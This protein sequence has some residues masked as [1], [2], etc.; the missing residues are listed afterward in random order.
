MRVCED[1]LFLSVAQLSRR[2]ACR[3][4]QAPGLGTAA[5][6]AVTGRGSAM[7]RLPDALEVMGTSL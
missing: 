2:L 3:R 1:V 4:E 6:A 7:G 5:G